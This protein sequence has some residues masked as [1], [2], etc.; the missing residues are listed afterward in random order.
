MYPKDKY[1]VP[2]AV[3][4][5]ACTVIALNN[6]PLPQ[7]LRT[8]WFWRDLAAGSVIGFG[9]WLC[10]RFISIRLDAR[11]AWKTAFYKRLAL[12]TVF[13]WALPS[14]LLFALCWLMFEWLVG[15]PF[16]ES[17]FPYYEYPFSVLLLALINGYYLVSA[18]LQK[19]EMPGRKEVLLAVKGAD[20]YPLRPETI[21]VVM[22]N[23][24]NLSVYTADGQKYSL[25]GTLDALEQ[26]LQK[27]DFYRIN[28]QVI[29]HVSAIRSY[30]AIE[31]GKIEINC[32][33]A[34]PESIIVSQKK[35]ADFRKWIS[36]SGVR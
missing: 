32:T 9:V 22:K 26:T 23:D 1:L 7:L 14:V 27:P 4:A 34:L 8:D 35:A 2:L 36:A 28:R 33:E 20:V 16:F 12:Q 17:Y 5:I 6:D 30:R 18:L 19:D 29:M 15:Q 24:T 21:R 11:V 25:S 31:N 10:I 13:G 3:P